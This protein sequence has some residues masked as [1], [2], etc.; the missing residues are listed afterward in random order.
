MYAFILEMSIVDRMRSEIK[1]SHLISYFLHI[2]FIVLELLRKDMNA[3]LIKPKKF[4]VAG[5]SHN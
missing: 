3:H 1:K 5:C 4:E 2:N